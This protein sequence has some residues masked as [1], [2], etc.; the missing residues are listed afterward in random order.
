[1]QPLL[2]LQGSKGD[3]LHLLDPALSGETLV[4][5]GY[6][7]TVSLRKGRVFKT[8]KQRYRLLEP[9]PAGVHVVPLSLT[10]PITLELRRT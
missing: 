4:A 7:T 3:T 1:M 5:Q 10:N 8:G 6:I 9:L 2:K